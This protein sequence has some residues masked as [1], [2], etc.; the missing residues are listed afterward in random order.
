MNF[1]RA[2][3]SFFLGSSI[4]WAS[5]EKPNF[6]DDIIPV[7][8]QSCNSCHNPDRARGGL[9]LTSINAILAGG[10]SGE[11]SIPGDPD[12]SLLYLLP[13]RLQEPHMPPRGEKIE[14]AQL[15]LIKNWIAQGMLPTASG[16]PMKKKKSS[17]NLALGS[18][19]I[20]KPEGPPPMPKY[21]ALQPALVTN[22]A[23]A[24]SAMA[25]APWSP[26]VALA[27][28]KQVIL[29]NTESLQISGILSYEEGFIESMNFSRNGKLVIAS[30]GRGGKSGNVAGWDIETGRRVL[31]VGE[32][33]DSILSAD[34]SADQSLVAIGGT[35]KLIKVFDLATNEILY[36]IKKHSEWVTQIA[37]SPDGI[38]LATADRNGG[39]FVWEAGTGNPFYTL[40]GHK[41]E[42]TSLSW[43]ADGNVLLS[44]SEEGA[45]RTWEMINGK[46]V[47][48]WNAHSGGTLSAHYAQN[49]NIVT[50]GRDKTVKFWDGN[51]KALRTI[52]GFADIVMETR[53]SHDGSKIIAG[54]WT[55][56][57][58]VWNSADGKH[59]GD[60]NANPPTLE[61]RT[62]LATQQLNQD[63]ASLAKAQ[64]LLLPF[65]KKVD[66]VTKQV[67]AN[68]SAL[69]VAEKALQDAVSAAQ[70]AK[71]ALDQAL[72]D[73]AN[74]T[75]IQSEKSA[76]HEA[77][78]KE[79][80]ANQQAHTAQAG[81]FNK[82]KQ[83][84]NDRSTQLS[85]FKE[86]YRKANE[87]QSQNQDDTSYTDAVNKAKLAME[88]MEKSYH[89]ASSLTAKHKAEMDKHAALNN[90]LNQAVQEAAKI[91]EE[92]K[93]YVTAS[94]DNKTKREESLK[95]SQANQAS[96]TTKRDQT[97][98]NLLNSEKLLAQ[99]K[100][101]I[102]KPATEVS[103]A[104]AT[105]K[106]CQ[107]HL[108]KWKAESINFTR[109]QEIL[110]LNSLEEDLGSLDELLEE[111]KNLFSSAQQAA[112]NAAAALSALPQKISEHQQVIAQKQSFVQ[113]ENS[114]LDQISLAKNQ[115]VSFIQQ[116]DQIQKENES[117][118]KLDP[119]NE[120]LRQAGAKL[121]ESLALLQKDLQSADSKL[122]SKQQE[123][124][125][126]KTAVTTAEAELAEIM[127][128]RESAPK[129]LE[130]KE[131]SLLDVQNQL[132][133]REKE[134]TEFKKKVDLQK[135]KTEALLQQYLEALP[136]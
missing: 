28:Q 129:V 93:K 80:A 3:V 45:V 34:I 103:Q 6:Q 21:L 13:A 63:Q 64:S 116:V 4:A 65:Q 73:L 92:A 56:K 60:L 126:A 131:K 74:K 132:K 69:Q 79:L 67:T 62:T 30:G 124:V 31:T 42:I 130:E 35:N 133:V 52:S 107:N 122:L 53:L 84:A 81:D 121:S 118:T 71:T 61:T 75:K 7:F 1:I 50:A 127:K 58:G 85:Q 14:K 101:E 12:S 68:K 11:V 72:A 125:Q 32:E 66:E 100:E 19:S 17:V 46:Q 102:K 77:K 40:D 111:S 33:Q 91:L 51:G 87:A 134:F 9:D 25:A 98:N 38:L 104:E 112:N 136:K 70:Q 37:F 23:F 97:K 117:Q 44:A 123:L 82:W 10:S 120:A 115:K 54:D 109:H 59:L 20:G 105:V 96:A 15:S 99:A 22:R 39:L 36:K 119:Q 48:T 86:S 27:G 135:S 8:E 5:T 26:L 43:R 114:K 128:M 106:S 113:S 47:R 78:N 16:K 2:I 49:G 57:V 94:V 95:Q 41:Q 108:S 90:T 29:Y 55:G 76:L 18:V 110:T 89:H 83:R 88:A 24:P